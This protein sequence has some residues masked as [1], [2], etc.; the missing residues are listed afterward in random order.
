MKHTLLATTALVAMT[1]AAAA[2]LTISATGR[3]GFM[4][5][6]GTA[7]VA[8]KTTYHKTTTSVVANHNLLNKGA[9][10]VSS[11]A[12]HI[13][14]NTKAAITIVAAGTLATSAD[15]AKVDVAIAEV[16]ARLN[17]FSQSATNDNPSLIAAGTTAVITQAT[18][19]LA[20]LQAIRARL[21]TVTAATAK[22]ADKT[23]AANRF[24]ISFKGTGETDS[25]IS[26]GISGRAEQS[27]TSL[28]GSQY[29]SGAFGKL[30][31][32]DLGGADNDATGHLAGVGLTG[33]GFNNE[34]SYQAV[35][36]N[37]GYEY[38]AAGITLG[39][40][41]N[42]A[43]TTGSNSALGLKYSGD[44]GGATISAGIGQSK[45][46]TAT[47]NTFAV[48]ASSGGLTL[49]AVSTTNDNGPAVKAAAGVTRSAQGT[50]AAVLDTLAVANNDTD[51][52]GISIS[53]SM[54][55][56]TVT[57]FTKKVSTTGVADM[58]YSGFGFAYDMG[59]VSLKAG[60]V[61]AND[62]QLVD[63]GL[64]FSF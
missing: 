12:L 47:Q 38:S 10:T 37:V 9:A 27:D 44:M 18:T 63:F 32:G 21:V 55:A 42:T 31:M 46:G 15:V 13:Y 59:G 58:D 41:Q 6:E 7:A 51:Q 3:V 35:N 19:D 30:K 17:G 24:R 50:T 5:T 61:D 29:V 64:S 34:F 54:D 33:L 16:K 60:V 22:V 56:M 11:I 45:V 49:K 8:E 62:Q 4:T 53:Y 26:Y 36:H 2:E 14:N 39:Y 23:E 43:I 20:T 48:S 25:G 28:A 40:S 57:G 1:G 52:A